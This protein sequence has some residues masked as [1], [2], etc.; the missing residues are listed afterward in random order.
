M[1][2]YDDGRS[3][4]HWLLAL[5]IASRDITLLDPTENARDTLCWM[6]ANDF[7]IAFLKTDPISIAKRDDLRDCG[8]SHRV[9]DYSK[10]LPERHVHAVDLS[11][12]SAFHELAKKRW[13]VLVHDNK[14][15]GI[16]TREDLAK[17]AAGAFVIAHL[18]TLERTLRRLFGSYTN[19]P[20]SDEPPANDPG[21]PHD[22][23]N[24]GIAYLSELFN[25]LAMIDSFVE[26]SG[27]SKQNFK[28]IGSWAVTIRNQL[29]GTHRLTDVGSEDPS[30]LER[31]LHIQ[32]LMHDSM[33]MLEERP[34]IWSAYSD[35]IIVDRLNGE[36]Y[37]GPGCVDLPIPAPAY[38]ITA[39]N[40]F[41]GFQSEQANEH[42][43]QML[44][45]VLK[46]KA[47]QIIEVVGSSRC[48]NWKENSFLVSGVDQSE[49]LDLARKYGQRAVFKLT[50]DKK[51]V[52]RADGEIKGE[53]SRHV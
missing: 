14:V 20:I 22:E 2:I 49:I 19:R 24:R 16:L 27:Y 17:P 44:Q 47:G 41:E 29:A 15:E 43:N 52:V 48:G 11:M 9:G 45:K 7:D 25:D 3:P 51:I 5:D 46:R 36:V 35:S 4:E 28:R 39:A 23:T 37:A 34:Q 50:K 1:T 33:R 38:V 26:D 12:N 6:K 13:F 18:I 21:M 32:K 42:R 10:G 40:P 30:I 31:T 8:E 53:T